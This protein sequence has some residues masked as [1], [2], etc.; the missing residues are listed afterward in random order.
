MILGSGPNRIGQ[1][2][3]FDYCCVSR[4]VRAARRR[5]RDRDDQLQPGNRVDRLRHGRPAVLRAADVR[6][7]DGD[8]RAR[9][10]RRARDVRVRRAVRRPD[11]AEAGAGAAGGRRQDHR[12]VAGFDRSRGRSRALREAAV[13]SRHSAAA[14]NGMATSREEAREVAAEDRLSRW[15]CARRT[16]SAAARWRSSTTRPRSIAT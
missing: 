5:V 1:G 6:R 12:H 15:S 14:P 2:I 3:E 7:R 9:A 10:Q 16:C 4:R 11:A 8:H 13:G